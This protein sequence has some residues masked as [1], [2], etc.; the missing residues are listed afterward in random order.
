MTAEEKDA[1]AAYLV[2]FAFLLAYALL[3]ATKPHGSSSAMSRSR[4]GLA[5]ER[6]ED[7]QC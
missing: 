2:V 6:K 3:I 7:E 1:A 5:R 4:R